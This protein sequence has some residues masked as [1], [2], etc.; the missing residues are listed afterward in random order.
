MRL[1]LC[2]RCQS[3]LTTSGDLV[4]AEF[5]RLNDPGQ[6]GRFD[7]RST[8]RRRDL[9]GPC[10]DAFNLW[11]GTPPAKPYH[12]A[13]PVVNEGPASTLASP[14]LGGGCVPAGAN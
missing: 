1:I 8:F 10:Y 2:D 13:Q 4:L 5:T 9:C 3:P 7:D 11:L 12:P 6:V 14:L